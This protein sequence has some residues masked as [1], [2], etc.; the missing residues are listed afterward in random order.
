MGKKGKKKRSQKNRNGL[1]QQLST[2]QLLQNLKISWDAGKWAEALT[3]YRTWINRT[4]KRRDSSIEGQILFR[5]A[6]YCFRMGKY[7]RAAALLDDA[8]IKD[9]DNAAD[10]SHYKAI[11]S[12]KNGQI[13][14]SKEILDRLDDDFHRTVLSYLIER[15]FPLSE[16]VSEYPVIEKSRLLAFWKTL[17]DSEGIPA[18][19]STLSHT[20]PSHAALKN[21]GSAFDIFTSGGDPSVPLNLLKKKTG[22]ELLSAEL[23]LISSVRMRNS[24]K[25]RSI[26]NNTFLSHSPHFYTAMKIHIIYLLKEKNYDEIVSLYKIFRKMQIK[27]PFME[28]AKDESFFQLGRK[29]IGENHL[30]KALDYFLGITRSTPAVLH[31]TALCYQKL[32]RYSEA[33]KYWIKLLRIEK[34]P[35]RS[36]PE[37]K[38]ISYTT[39]IK[40]IAQ[41]F[42]QDGMPEKA[43]EYF[44][45]VLM[46]IK[47]DREALES[48]FTITLEIEKYSESLHFS[49]RLYEL[50]PNNEEYLLN[51]IQELHYCSQLDTLI[52][53]YQKQIKEYPD[54]NI[55]KGGLASCYLEQAW[56]IRK[57][58]PDE[59]ERIM[60]KAK[61]LTGT[62]PKLLYLEGYFLKREGKKSEA[63]KKFEKAIYYSNTH[64]LDYHLGGGFYEDGMVTYAMRQFKDIASCHCDESDILFERSVQFLSDKDD[65]KNTI[66]LCDYG[67]KKKEY[68]LYDISEMLYDFHKASWAKEYSS[69]LILQD[70][71]DEDHM[72]LHLIILN[73]IGNKEVTL[74]YAR[75]F[76]QFFLEKNDHEGIMAS[77]EIIRQI[78]SR[79][80]FKLQ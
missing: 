7:D 28:K 31:N 15:N 1:S 43:Y 5:A 53:I 71:P 41:N 58:T 47:D 38:L 48:L 73:G 63:G 60:M 19:H 32:Q 23:L 55:F 79:G 77:K 22:Y 76:H 25:I 30:Q 37:N 29:E 50:E 10:Y 54:T 35:K 36:D 66:M 80:R 21:I 11:C 16:G 6:S 12:A 72:F 69:R 65:Y 20:N 9:P 74:S 75:R 24:T 51:Y 40:Y 26:I 45:E 18:S 49:K 27:S 33:N 8:L 39:T 34:K 68:T 56:D 42:M 17:A 59:A 13:G 61:K 3:Y 62:H 44:K 2:V 70:D 14:L 57:D 52:P 78:K 46:Y 4:G 64:S 67:I